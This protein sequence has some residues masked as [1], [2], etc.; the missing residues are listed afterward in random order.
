M[1]VWAVI[2]VI[3]EA[4]G[5]GRGPA[6]VRSIGEQD[7]LIT[8]VPLWLGALVCCVLLRKRD[9]IVTTGAGAKGY[10]KRAALVAV[11]LRIHEERITCVEGR[12]I[13]NVARFL[14]GV[15]SRI[16]G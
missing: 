11:L 16:S 1:C 3:A 13:V 8:E 6:K 15:V 9:L 14:C 5:V 12:K 10:W 4:V 2:P 7:T